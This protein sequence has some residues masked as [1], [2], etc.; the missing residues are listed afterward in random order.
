[1]LKRENKPISKSF[2]EQ[3][4]TYKP[5]IN[6]KLSLAN[7]KRAKEESQKQI[8]NSTIKFSEATQL[9]LHEIECRN[10]EEVMRKKNEILRKQEEAEAKQE[11]LQKMR[12]FRA[13]EELKLKEK[14]QH[15]LISVEDI[16]DIVQKK[17]LNT[18]M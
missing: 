4:L 8:V 7:F 18:S 12:N 3:E 2:S 6:S 15:K 10:Y 14:L 1:M 11:F 16:K 13:E 17:R 5:N 9:H